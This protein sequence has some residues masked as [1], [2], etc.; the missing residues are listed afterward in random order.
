MSKRQLRVIVAGAAGYTGSELVRLLANHPA[1]AISAFVSSTAAGSN[2]ADKIQ[3]WRGRRQMAF[4][5]LDNIGDLPGDVVFFATPHAVAMRHAPALLDAGKVVIDLGADFRL[6]DA[7]VF[8]QWYGEHS[9]PELLPQA[10]YGL[11]ETA[12]EKIKT[13]NLIACPGC[14]ATAIALALLPFV[15]GG[16]RLGDVIADAKSGTS[17]AGRQNGRTDLL[18]AEMANNYKAYGLSGH[19][20]HPEI[21]QTLATAGKATPPLTFIPHLLPLARGLFANLYFQ[22]QTPADA[23][24][25]LTKYWRDNPF[26]EVLPPALTAELAHAIGGNRLILSAHPLADERVLICATLDNLIKGA[27]GQAVQNMNIRFGL[28]E[29]SG[30]AGALTT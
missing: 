17:G 14:Y 26:I 30:L 3:F 29:T 1:A 12:R 4:E 10:V 8:R 27:A 23:G 16:Y 22:M 6:Q 20:H 18:L 21:M 28:E 2:V 7:T 15:D 25:I 24:S 13:A 9:A 11:P 5:P 19:R